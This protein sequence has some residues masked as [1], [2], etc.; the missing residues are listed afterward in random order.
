MTSSSSLITCKTITYIV[1]AVLFIVPFS[2]SAQTG[3][4][5]SN[6]WANNSVN[7][8]I[9]RKNALV[10]YQNT[11]YA[12]YYDSNQFVVLAKRT[13]GQNK[14]QLRRT[15]YQGDATDAH[16]SISIIV[17]GAGYLH[18]AWGQHNNALNYAKAISPGSLQLGEKLSMTGV[19][20][21]KVSYPEFYRLPSG[22][23]LFLY[24][25]GGSGNGNLMLNSYSL[26]THKWTSV[27]DGLIDGEGQRNAYWQM[28]IDAKGTIHLSWVWRETPDVASNHDMCYA[29][30]VDGGKTWQKSTGEKYQLPINASNAEYACKIPQHSE[31]INQTSMFADASGKP[32]IATYWR[33]ENQTVPQY[34]LV[35]H[36]DNGWKV[37]NLSFRKTP[38]SLSGAGTKSIPISRP[39]I[40]AW[41]NG[42][43]QSAAIIFRDAERGNQ[44]SI[45]Q[46][47][48][49]TGSNWKVSDITTSQVGAWE[50]AYDT[51]LWKRKQVLDLF[52][53]AV[54]QI[55]GEGIGNNQPKPVSVLEWKPQTIKN[56]IK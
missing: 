33:E 56:N 22:N 35:Y 16:K 1:V 45:A 36:T 27:Q 49:I 4:I 51:E 53:Q 2:V 41:R 7:T 40:I 25:D 28:A 24:R 44:V 30:S 37:S 13:T 29:Q 38:F 5:S 31:L 43:K 34:H 39:Q 10:T 55:D 9:F 42:K 17:D 11:Q 48:D 12:A 46:S 18:L 21:N 19:K 54:I 47:S 3:V 20:E 26:N 32:F 14:W 6:G 52:I 8:V 15:T 23:L 50:P